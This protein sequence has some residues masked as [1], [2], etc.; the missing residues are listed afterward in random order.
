MKVRYFW[1]LGLK[2]LR[3]CAMLVKNII[4]VAVCWFRAQG[5][6]ETFTRVSGGLGQ[7]FFFWLPLIWVEVRSCSAAWDGRS[8]QSCW[9]NGSCS[10]PQSWAPCRPDRW[11][12]GGGAGWKEQS[13][14][15]GTGRMEPLGRMRRRWMTG[16]HPESQNGRKRSQ[17]RLVICSGCRRTQTSSTQEKTAVCLQ[18]AAVLPTLSKK[19]VKQY[20]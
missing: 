6:K 12:I 18:T 9:R 13:W 3:E 16:W 15:R 20:L 2:G 1:N 17:R 14:A 8:A 5:V 10:P 11:E 7:V 19:K 4:H